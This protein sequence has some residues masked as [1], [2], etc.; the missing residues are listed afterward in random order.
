M[1]NLE[2]PKEIDAV[3]L[4]ATSTWI[5]EAKQPKLNFEAIGQVLAHS[6][7]FRRGEHDLGNT[8]DNIKLGIICEKTDEL[9]EEVCNDYNIKVFKI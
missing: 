2:R 3:A 4:T 6:Y 8:P 1:L 9:L 5:L 7:F